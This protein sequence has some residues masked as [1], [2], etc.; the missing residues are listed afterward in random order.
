MTAQLEVPPAQ[1]EVEVVGMPIESLPPLPREVMAELLEKVSL[2]SA[3]PGEAV[4]A[5]GQRGE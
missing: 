3:A 1:G 2:R 4:I 5:E